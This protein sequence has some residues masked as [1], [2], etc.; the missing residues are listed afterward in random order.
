[1][2]AEHE[3]VKPGYNTAL[4]FKIKDTGAGMTKEQLAIMFEEYSRFTTEATRT[5]E[6]TGLGMSITRN[7]VKLM[8]GDI[9]VQSEV[10]KGTEF[11]I[12][13]PQ[14]IVSDETMSAELI[15]NLKRFTFSNSVRQ[16][17]SS[18]I[19]REPMPY[20][21]VLIVDDVD[22]NIYVAKGLLSFYRL[23]IDTAVSGYEAIEKVEAG[24]VDDVV[25][26]DHMMPQM[27][28]IEATRIIRG[29][30]YGKPI[31]A[32]TA[33]A[34]AGQAELFLTNGF[35]AFVSKPIDMRE[36][37]AAL[38][39]FVRD[40]QPPEVVE[41]ARLMYPA[42]AA[43]Q[44]ETP[45]EVP[46]ELAKIFTRDAARAITTLDAICGKDSAENGDFAPYTIQAH[47]MKAALANIGQA[48]LAEE[49]GRLE[50]AGREKNAEVVR[51]ETPA[52]LA[53]L[54]ALVER[55]APQEKTDAAPLSEENGEMLKTAVAAIK[56]ACDSLNKKAA[57][58]QLA[59]LKEGI[60]PRNVQDLLDKL[61]THILHSDFE[62]AA[63]AAGEFLKGYE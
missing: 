35:D 18:Q 58:E 14:R 47:A 48:E 1:V 62:E 59:A 41:A 26:M 33:N 51:E 40:A 4:V 56:K 42:P 30:G 2:L 21:K 32:L 8:N 7:L 15:D 13:L 16:T 57:K 29:M 10:G 44:E 17:K 54:A 9:T 27:D 46:A 20:G 45:S 28:G 49:A 43:T 55:L 23:Q 36:L 19:E 3:N 25:F 37:N 39:K 60:W 63:S 38:N 22:T 31:V 12:T 50:E 6:G 5:T 53:K 34:V 52:F 61:S 11:A 24:N